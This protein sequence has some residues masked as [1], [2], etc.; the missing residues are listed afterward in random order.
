MAPE[1]AAL[2][3][4]RRLG[5]AARRAQLVGVGLE[6][7]AEGSLDDVTADAVAAQAGVSKGLVF[8]Y[9]PTTR[10]LQVAVLRVKAAELVA[11]VDAAPEAA[12]ADR[13]LAGLDA[14]VAFIEVQPRTYRALVRSAGSDPQL[15]AIFEETRAAVVG[16]IASALGTDVLPV[17][18]RLTLRGWLAL[19]EETTLHWLDEAPVPRADLV[20][21]LH[22]SALALLADPLALTA[23]ASIHHG[24]GSPV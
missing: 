23:G 11:S 24:G 13:L 22:R 9:Y 8:H 7:L 3:P 21:F 16:L 14:Y 17:G 5:P 19:V 20:A 2:T 4:R 6:L 10:D 1:P 18:L 12:P 15:L